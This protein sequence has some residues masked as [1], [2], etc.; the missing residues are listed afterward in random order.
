MLEAS[1]RS[2]PPAS[3]YL[4]GTSGARAPALPV[5]GGPWRHPRRAAGA[6]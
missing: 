4:G 1:A 2:V 5:S 6:A 3:A